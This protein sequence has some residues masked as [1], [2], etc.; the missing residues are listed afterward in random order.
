MSVDG[1]D[2]MVPGPWG[3]D[4]C[5]A[6]LRQIVEFWVSGRAQIEGRSRSEGETDPHDRV[7]GRRSSLQDGG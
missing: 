6:N 3:M 5:N 2:S 7:T 4:L 1:K